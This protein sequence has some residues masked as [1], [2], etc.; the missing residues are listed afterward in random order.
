MKQ[1]KKARIKLS[2]IAFHDI[3]Y[4]ACGIWDC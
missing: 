2:D 3:I 1:N 4:V